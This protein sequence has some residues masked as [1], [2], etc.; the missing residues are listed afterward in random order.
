MVFDGRSWLA[1]D[2]VNIGKLEPLSSHKASHLCEKHAARMKAARPFAGGSVK[3]PR[4]TFTGEPRLD[5]N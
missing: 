4:V 2:Q 5:D 1:L 3:P